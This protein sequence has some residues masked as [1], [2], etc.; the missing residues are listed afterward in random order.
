MDPDL[1]QENII[2]DV[3]VFGVQG[4]LDVTSQ[5]KTYDSGWFRCSAAGTYNL[6]H[7]LGTTRLLITVYWADNEFELYMREAGKGSYYSG[8]VSGGSIMCGADVNN[9]TSSTLTVQAGSGGPCF[10]FAATGQKDNIQTGWYRA[11]ALALE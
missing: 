4:T 6:T 5:L 10:G 8:G 3:E 9:I 7:N 2:K 11:V 1:A